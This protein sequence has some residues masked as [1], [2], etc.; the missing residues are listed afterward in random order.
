[1]QA[2]TNHMEDHDK[3]NTIHNII[4]AISSQFQLLRNRLSI[5]PKSEQNQ[6]KIQDQ[7]GISIKNSKNNKLQDPN[8]STGKKNDKNLRQW[9]SENQPISDNSQSSISITEEQHILI[10]FKLE[11]TFGQPVQEHKRKLI[12]KMINSDQQVYFGQKGHKF[13]LSTC[14]YYKSNFERCSIKIAMLNK[15]SL[16]PCKKCF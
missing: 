9:I 2:K 7:N 13:H 10:K 16:D 6:L 15:P 5:V 11:R 14:Q 4:Y 3:N 8:C 12:E 1:M